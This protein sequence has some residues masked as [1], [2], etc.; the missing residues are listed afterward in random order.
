MPKKK[1]KI[2]DWIEKWN[3]ERLRK[4]KKRSGKDLT[5]IE[6]INLLRFIEKYFTHGFWENV[7][8]YQPSLK[9]VEEVWNRFCSGLEY[10]K[11][12]NRLLTD[13][14]T[15]RY[16]KKEKKLE[17]LEV[18]YTEKDVLED[19]KNEII[20]HY[21]SQYISDIYKKDV[22]TYEVCGQ[23]SEHGYECWEETETIKWNEIF[24]DKSHP[25]YVYLHF[26]YKCSDVYEEDVFSFRTQ[27]VEREQDI[28]NFLT[29]F[30]SMYNLQPATL[31]QVQLIAPKPYVWLVTLK[32]TE[33]EDTVLVCQ[34][35][36]ETLPVLRGLPGFGMLEYEIRTEPWILVLTHKLKH[37]L[38]VIAWNISGMGILPGK[39]KKSHIPGYYGLL[40]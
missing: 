36:A 8:P 18:E 39:S 24:I 5:Y 10:E 11:C 13:E 16:V 26:L 40:Y 12:K 38:G 30:A 23:V 4:S 28:Y 14:T 21:G 27:L 29:H 17:E 32:G 19:I 31:P 20:K 7:V 37:P 25:L 33:R 35:D 22:F 1:R 34:Y 3:R 6:K 15:R 9:A 2:T